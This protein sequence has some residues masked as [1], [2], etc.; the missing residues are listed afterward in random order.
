MKIVAVEIAAAV[1]GG[2]ALATTT[3]ARPLTAATATPVLHK[4]QPRLLRLDSRVDRS[5][6]T[7]RRE[8]LN[9]RR[10]GA[11]RDRQG[12]REQ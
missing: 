7:I 11:A 1:S 10:K 8:W 3:T 5:R 6:N 4:N 12:Y 9:R 2:G